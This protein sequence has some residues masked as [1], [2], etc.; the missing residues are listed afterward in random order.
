MFINHQLK[1]IGIHKTLEIKC[2]DLSTSTVEALCLWN[3]VA[4][5]C[6]V[7]APVGTTA[8]L[9]CRQ[10]FIREVRYEETHKSVRCQTDGSWG[11]TPMTCSKKPRKVKLVLEGD[12]IITED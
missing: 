4:V 3:N 11:P 8:E 12:M 5:S 2:P 10:G 1:L 6:Q 7:P 9:N